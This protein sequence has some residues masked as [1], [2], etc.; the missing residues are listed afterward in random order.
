MRSDHYLGG[1][2]A[3]TAA[4]LTGQYA[5]LLL[6]FGI[7]FFGYVMKTTDWLRAIP[8]DIIDARFNSVILEHLY[9][10]V[11][12]KAPS[13]WSPAFFY[14]FEG[15]LAFSDNHIGSGGAYVLFRLAGLPREAAYQGWF[16]AACVLNFWG[17]YYALRRLGFT[18]VAAACGAF[19]FAFGLPALAKEAH[20]QLSWRFAVPLA[21]LSF[22]RA[23]AQRDLRQLGYTALWCA[24]QFFCSIYLGIF[25]VYLLL[26][27]LLAFL[28]GQGREL[29]AGW[30]RGLQD[31]SSMSRLGALALFL[32]SA[33][34]VLWLLQQYQ[35]IASHYG[36]TRTTREILSMLPT[37]G[38]YLVADGSSL[39]GWVG[40]SV[41][42]YLMR[43]ELQLFAGL[44]AWALALIG[45]WAIWR[46]R[47]HSEIGRTATIALLVLVLLTLLIGNVTLYRAVLHVPGMSS[48]RAVSRI[49]LVMLLPF[50]ILVAVGVDWLARLPAL[51]SWRW[52]TLLVLIGGLSAE[53]VSYRPYSTFAQVWRDR[54]DSLRA[55]LPA[56][57][58]PRDSIVF[59]TGKRGA[60]VLEAA[61]I[62]GMILAQ[63]R[64]VAT[65]NGY[66]GNSPPGYFKPDPCLDFRNRLDSY[67]AFKPRTTE[68]RDA[69]TARVRVISPEPCPVTPGMVGKEPVDTFVAT[70]ISLAATFGIIAYGRIYVDVAITNHTGKEFSTWSTRGPVR[71]SWRCVPIGPDGKDLASPDFAG[72]KELDF[73]LGDDQTIVQ[74]IDMDIPPR[75][76]YRIEVTLVQ[77]G[78]AWFHDLGMG[79]ASVQVEVP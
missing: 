55:L 32:A 77:D 38:S 51:R 20:A 67:F 49:V 62:D 48:V 59:V 78:V 1:R 18:I 39:S 41:P 75:G 52:I 45:L 24:V 42:K 61:E 27:T 19:V 63:D 25:T 58:L 5:L 31:Q 16:I 60:G 14:P 2:S 73:I 34:A 3:G 6:I 11:T 7:G 29:A 9:Q 69:L 53:S 47:A 40:A 43:H 21:F 68:S 71:L 57:G 28:F 30:R 36:F 50:G 35:S 46:R 10:W 72:R 76:S 66:S 37:P 12:G 33:A 56:D 44:G 74:S 64:G 79:V 4:D 65:L 23:M 70:H 54:Q 13:L 15:V 22:Y 26:A 17:S 8:G